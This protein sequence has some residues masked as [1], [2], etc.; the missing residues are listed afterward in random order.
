MDMFAASI[1]YN[2]SDCPIE[3]PFVHALTK[4]C[5]NCP[6]GLNFNLGTKTCDGCPADAQFSLMT[7]NC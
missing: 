5:F 4:D 7:N 1:K 6:E 2:L 3:R